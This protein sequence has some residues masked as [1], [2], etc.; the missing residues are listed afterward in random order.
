M[1]FDSFMRSETD[2]YYIPTDDSVQ[3]RLLRRCWDAAVKSALD[4]RTCRHH[5]T[6]TGGCTSVVRCREG[7]EYQ[8]A[9]PRRCWETEWPS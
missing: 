3:L 2:G 5:T 9:T 6:A 8:P 7:S 4:C 1:T